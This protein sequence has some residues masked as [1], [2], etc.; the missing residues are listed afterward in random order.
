[1]S[2]VRGKKALPRKVALSIGLLFFGVTASAGA[3][4]HSGNGGDAY[5]CMDSAAH[6]KAVLEII[7]SNRKADEKDE[8]SGRS[9]RKKEDPFGVSPGVKGQLGDYVV[10]VRLLDMWETRNTYRPYFEDFWSKPYKPKVDIPEGIRRLD[11]EGMSVDANYLTPSG[12]RVYDTHRDRHQIREAWNQL[13]EKLGRRSNL[14]RGFKRL[15]DY[16]NWNFVDNSVVE[17]DDSY[18]SL[19]AGTNCLVV[20]MVK[21]RNFGFGN[22]AEV[23]VSEF[24]YKRLP[25][26]D[27][28]ALIPHEEGIL[29]YG[30]LRDT[31][32]VRRAA[33]LMTSKDYFVLSDD[34]L[35]THFKRYGVFANGIETVY[36]YADTDFTPYNNYFQGDTSNFSFLGGLCIYR[37]KSVSII[38]GEPEQAVRVCDYLEASTRIGLNQADSVGDVEKMINHSIQQ[39]NIKLSFLGQN[40]ELSPD[41]AAPGWYRVH[42]SPDFR[43]NGLTFTVDRLQ[44]ES[45]KDA[46]HYE[47]HLSKLIFQGGHRVSFNGPPKMH[48]SR[49]YGYSYRLEKIE[50]GDAKD[51]PVHRMKVG[52]FLFAATF[53]EL[54]YADTTE[55]FFYVDVKATGEGNFLF[56]DPG[57]T[58]RCVLEQVYMDLK[59]KSCR[60]YGDFQYQG[61]Q[62]ISGSSVSFYSDLNWKA[63]NLSNDVTMGPFACFGAESVNRVLGRRPLEYDSY[64]E[65][66]RQGHVRRCWTYS[67]SSV[68]VG[69]YSFFPLEVGYLKDEITGLGLYKVTESEVYS[70]PHGQRLSSVTVGIVECHAEGHVNIYA[71]NPSQIEGCV[72]SGRYIGSTS[73]SPG[74]SLPK[75]SD[76][77]IKVSGWVRFYPDGSMKSFAPKETVVLRDGRGVLR[78][79]TRY[80]VSQDGDLLGQE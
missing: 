64:I 33:T 30:R 21:H 46:D 37:K 9:T 18:E 56:G 19:I 8:G 77:P 27:K 6:K 23:N 71:D 73:S 38:K 80:L 7:N 75:I 78:P 15:A 61:A 31:T 5:V 47:L 58:G 66:D 74:V 67:Q 49:Q 3:G 26:V 20:Q 76:Q 55:P 43:V 32:K 41:M 4:G 24:L 53:L 35:Y 52:P 10:S 22:G 45:E 1:M 63:G 28:L 59:V 39:Q 65:R 79:G 25:D 42:N 51:G 69:R 40:I 17:V 60:A 12:D 29:Y 54:K 72:S 44:S 57:S 70:L 34:E 16:L 48:L 11:D 2:L 68:S 13:L 62:F 36:T 14:D 50:F